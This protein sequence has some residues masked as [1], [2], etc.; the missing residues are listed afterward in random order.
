MNE[1]ER[2]ICARL[3]EL[4]RRLKLSQPNFAALTGISLNQLA[5]IEYGR[6]PLRYDVAWIIRVLFN[7]SLEWLSIGDG[8]PDG[9][10]LDDLPPPEASKLPNSA[11]LSEVSDKF[12]GVAGAQDAKQKSGKPRFKIDED[13]LQHRSFVLLALKI[14]LEMWISQIPDGYTGD[15]TDRLIQFANKYL[16]TLPED[17]GELISLRSEALIWEKMRSDVASRLAGG[18]VLKKCLTVVS[19]SDNNQ[20]VKPKLPTLLE[21]LKKTTAQRGRKSELAKFLGV[22]LVQVSQWL[23]GDREPGGETT[24][25]LLHW[26]EQSERQK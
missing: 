10:N 16:E 19:E 20:E 11:L 9:L 14:N 15:F 7:V 23:S 26:V 1:R 5:S 2:Q 25:R 22:S 18:S 24:L 3:K 12:H 13:E 4:R 21:R 6:T 8:F 17:P